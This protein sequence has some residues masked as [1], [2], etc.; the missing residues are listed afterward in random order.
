[1]LTSE[2]A[3]GLR[4]LAKALPTGTAV[5]VPRELLLELLG[6]SGAAPAEL[7]PADLTVADLCGQ[8]G[9]KPSAVRAWLERGTSG[10]H[11]SSRGATGGY[12]S[13]RWKPTV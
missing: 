13:R 7:A 4:A 2:I 6:G 12:R 9:R 5:P 10:V 11:T 3:A 1:M 8:F